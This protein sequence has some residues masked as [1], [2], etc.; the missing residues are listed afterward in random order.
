VES[1]A[2]GARALTEEGTASVVCRAPPG[3]IIGA[4]YRVVRKLGEG[5][6]GAV[7]LVEH[8]HMRKS[9]ALKLLRGETLPS[10]E[11]VAR[12]EREA[13]AAGNIDHPNVAKATDFGRLCDGECFLVL[14]YVR[15]TS[16]RD[17]LDGGPILP[18]RALGI[19][20]QI[21]AGLGAAHTLGFV[22][23]DIKPENVML[24]A[25]EDGADEVKILDFGIA[26]AESRVEG[27]I[28]GGPLLTRVGMIV[29][30]PEYM[31]P[32]QAVGQPVDG[33]AD[34]YAVGVILFE[35]I[36]GVRPFE[37]DAMTL[38]G[39]H[40]AVLP[41]ELTSPLAPLTSELRCLVETL[42][43]KSREERPADAAA[44]IAAVDHALTSLAGAPLA[45][46]TKIVAARPAQRGV[47]KA[48]LARI[49][50]RIDVVVAAAATHLS[51]RRTT[52]RRI[53]IAV[54]VIATVGLMALLLGLCSTSASIDETTSYGA[55]KPEAAKAPAVSATVAGATNTI[56][57]PSAPPAGSSPPT[58]PEE[59]LG[60]A[61][62]SLAKAQVHF[63][64]AK[65][66]D[67]RTERHHDHSSSSVSFLPARRR[68]AQGRPSSSSQC[69]RHTL[70][71]AL[72]TLGARSA[73]RVATTE[74]RRAP[75]RRDGEDDG[76][77][78]GE[79][80]AR[81]ASA[82][83][84]VLLSPTAIDEAVNRSDQ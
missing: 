48:T 41:P 20:R 28:A 25:R 24:V 8:V 66:A 11:M 43:A 1:N 4:R 82:P 54:S 27:D 62:E 51:L 74:L 42:L 21:L 80:L 58:S 55:R 69:P 52:A 29:G 49:L 60:Q 79:A 47:G 18:A 57:T 16:L 37:G 32:E 14:E 75:D 83:A 46:P 33:R 19:A 38:L 56:P 5:G 50:T 31:S 77:A 35:M 70:H 26:R 13:M 10:S 30:T 84:T 6:M 67:A 9:F 34:L 40:V 72:R 2:D 7:Y 61:E 3:A 71:G 59:E 63:S 64:I 68:R 76:A 12:F 73:R 22:H 44:A 81:K 17:V 15:G 53:A 45:A 78:L 23:R 39:K 65:I 36:S